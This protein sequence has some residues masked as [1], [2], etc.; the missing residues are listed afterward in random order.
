M[1]DREIELL[2]D[3]MFDRR[4]VINIG[5]GGVGRSTLTAL[6]A[7][8][9]AERGK[10]VL[11]CE[12]NTRA[13]MPEFFGRKSPSQLDSLDQIWQI[14]PNIWTVNIQ[15][16]YAIKEYVV[17]VLGFKLLYN[18]VFENRFVRGFLHGVP[19]LQELVFL[20]KIWY[21]AENEGERF[22]LVIVDSPATGHGLALLRI[23]QVVLK[24]SPPGR[25]RK[26]VER[27]Q[28]FISS[29]QNTWINLISLPEELPVNETIELYRRL[30]GELGLPI[31][32]VRV[33]QWPP[34]PFPREERELFDRFR[35]QF[36]G[37]A[38]LFLQLL[39]A[40]AER[41]VSDLERAR[42]HLQALVEE[43]PRSVFLLP[44]VLPEAGSRNREVS[45][46]EKLLSIVREGSSDFL[47]SPIFADV[48][49]EERVVF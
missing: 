27:I 35:E 7:V 48:S 41:G 33:N 12:V 46:L 43:V 25:M 40:V 45:I 23:P 9:A 14:A 8:L 6:L 34:A 13:R 38:P 26:E 22:D 3:S 29:E 31:G 5:K 28:S 30:D 4:L 47:F 32:S 49:S 19:G 15:L 36:G 21:H 24:I 16:D 44:A 37:R 17:R 42:L 2:L 20:G 11:I 10:R 39:L 18:L 1:S